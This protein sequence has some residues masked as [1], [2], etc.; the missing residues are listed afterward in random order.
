LRSQISNLRSQMLLPSSLV[1]PSSGWARLLPT[2][3]PSSPTQPSPRRDAAFPK[4]APLRWSFQACSFSLSHGGGMVAGC[5]LRWVQDA[6]AAVAV[7]T[8]QP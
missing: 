7:F 8:P 3:R 2:A 4:R 5:D 6:V 1:G